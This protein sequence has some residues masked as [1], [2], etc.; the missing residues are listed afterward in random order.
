MNKKWVSKITLLL[1]FMF[2]LTACGGGSSKQ[3]S[4]G[5]SEIE[6]K[7]PAVVE[8]EGEVIDGSNLTLKVGVVSDSPYKG[9][10]NGFLYKDS[11]DERFMKYTMLGAFPIDG[12]LKL[13]ADSDETPIK[14][15]FDLE[16]KTVNYKINPKFKWSNG[17]QVTTAD[18]VKTYE[19]VANN[20]YI[21]SAK[22]VRYG[23][24]MKII[25]GIEEYNKGKADKIS[26]L[27]VI[28]DSNM[29][30]HLKEMTP[31]IY[32][33]GPFVSEFVNAKQFEGVAMN[34]IIESPALRQNP[35][36]YGPYVMNSQVMG[37]KILFEANPY[38]YKGEP[39]IKNLE[40]Q[41]LP[42]SQQV[43]SM[44]SG[45]YDIVMDANA[46]VFP[47]IE[48]LE[49]MTIASRM[50]LYM[51]YLGFRV[52][53]YDRQNSK[54]ITD[55]NSKMYD[56][57]LRKAMGHAIDNDTI[58]E[59]FY[60]GLRFH[61]VSPIAPIFKNLHDPEIKGIEFDMD[62]AKSLLDEAGYK[63]VDGDGFREDKDGN[64]LVINYASMTGSEIAEPLAQ[65]NIQ[66]WKDIGLNVKL[67]NGRLL[68]LN[69]FYDKLEA[70]DPQ[71]DVF[72]AAF[73]LASDPN[74]TGLYGDSEA[75]NYSRYTSDK[76]Q[77]SL[78]A[79]GSNEALDPE[80][81]AKLY[82]EFEKIFQEESPSIPMLNRVEFMPINKRIKFYD[83]SMD[84]ES[85]FDW[86]KIE[87]TAEEP[88]AN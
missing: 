12:D 59:K 45:K 24:E 63:D 68:D 13:I 26:G 5:S 3:K 53:T 76:L 62:K 2:L 73:G 54:I 10:F 79:L 81:Q 87:L 88:I 86:S 17:E 21:V 6:K 85:G 82:H 67:L 23:D 58:G 49:N 11:I 48:P 34:K 61:A 32:W 72:S 56:V 75:F 22:S 1:A 14:L 27:E 52:G 40:M 9:I 65:Y 64:P 39:N 8:N 78:E 84:D 41:I 44:E 37:E 19:I 69:N 55:T 74:P 66:Q 51:S 77:S 57:N 25:E 47:Q 31:G 60:N 18:I 38:Y 80:N 29:K 50:D 4:L 30:I 43:A 15:T 20:D 7:Y 46:D 42:P 70:D 16:N 36:S 28:D 71:I 83:W 35:L 33:G